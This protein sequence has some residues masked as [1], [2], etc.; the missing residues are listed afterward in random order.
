M[1]TGPEGVYH[2]CNRTG[3]WVV[4]GVPQVTRWCSMAGNCMGI[5]GTLR[6]K[7]GRDGMAE[8]EASNIGQD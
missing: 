5:A 4:T 8:V 2:T 3:T 6:W 7:E 1:E